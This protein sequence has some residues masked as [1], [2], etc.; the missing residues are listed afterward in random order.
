MSALTKWLDILAQ[1]LKPWLTLRQVHHAMNNPLTEDA[2]S[3]P[4]FT[5]IGKWGT[6]GVCRHV[7]YSGRT[8]LNPSSSFSL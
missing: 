8:L 3:V 5:V 7:T 2:D 6:A 4:E 1:S